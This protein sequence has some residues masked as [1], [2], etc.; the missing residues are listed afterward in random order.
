MKNG[1]LFM[2]SNSYF[3]R[4]PFYTFPFKTFLQVIDKLEY[5]GEE[6]SPYEVSPGTDLCISD[7][8]Y[9]LGFLTYLHS[10]GRVD[11]DGDE[12][13]LNPKG[14]VPP[15]KPYRFKLISDAVEI[16][17]ALLEGHKNVAEI[18]TVVSSLSEKAIDDYLNVLRLL[19]QKAK[20]VQRATGWDATF[21]LTELDKMA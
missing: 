13:F 16:L 15:E 11:K 3:N 19:S 14:E 9:S 21:I 10:F 12:W 4:P 1:G 8:Y 7:T 17:H 6:S 18:Q 5:L 2:A 20:F